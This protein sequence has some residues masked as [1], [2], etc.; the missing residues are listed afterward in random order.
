M[1]YQYKFEIFPK[2]PFLFLILLVFPAFFLYGGENSILRNIRLIA[3]P[4]INVLKEGK[5]LQSVDH[6]MEMAFVLSG[7]ENES[8]EYYI[9]RFFEII[10]EFK[11]SQDDLSDLKRVAENMLT[12][13]HEHVFKKYNEKQTKLDVLLDTGV[14]NCVSSAVLYSIALSS[15][16][17]DVSGVRTIDHAFCTV[18]IGD[19]KYDVETTN[20]Y[21]FDPGSKKDFVNEFGDITGFNY[22]P[23][24]HYSKRQNIDKLQLISLILHNRITDLYER[25]QYF[26]ALGLA[27]DLYYL[28]EDDESHETFIGA[29]Q[30]IGAYINNTGLY[31][32]G[33]ECFDAIVKQY[34]DDIKIVKVYQSLYHN[35][36]VKLIDGKSYDKALMTCEQAFSRL[37]LTETDYRDF[38]V[39]I[40]TNQANEIART[41]YPQALAFLEQAFEKIGADKRLV[42]A[43]VSYFNNHIVDLLKQKKIEQADELVEG[44]YKSSFLNKIDYNKFK[45]Y[46]VLE[47]GSAIALEQGYLQ[48]ARFLESALKSIGPNSNI[49]QNISIYLR[50]YEVTIHNQAIGLYQEDKIQEAVTLLEQALVEYPDSKQL[51]KDLEKIRPYL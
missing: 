3:L 42:S 24:G 46:V 27:V 12:Y 26:D 11:E 32:E 16:G 51:R 9:D 13:L 49:S 31:T 8:I 15:F 1:R 17:I 37:I 20:L 10:R 50:N 28:L 4:E 35:Y 6:L 19:T 44:S 29:I 40:F 41:S 25:N 36:I 14:F 7:T 48:A 21:G 45:G 34:P 30:N 2:M 38:I 33:L 39:I 47:Q 43:Q 18:K 5:N 23:P 22:V